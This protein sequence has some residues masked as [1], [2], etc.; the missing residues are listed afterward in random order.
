MQSMRL[1][2][3]TCRNRKQPNPS[4]EPE[5]KLSVVIFIRKVSDYKFREQ[6]EVGTLDE[7][8]ALMDEFGEDLIV[9]RERSGDG[10]LDV[11]IYD[12]YYE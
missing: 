10:A 5:R 4:R 8:L 7:L 3:A 12:D 6:R 9:K 11:I 1:F 2:S